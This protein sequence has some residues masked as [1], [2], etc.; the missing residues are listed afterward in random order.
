MLPVP[1]SVVAV[2]PCQGH[3]Q[4]HQPGRRQ[5]RERMMPFVCFVR[6]ELHQQ[7]LWLIASGTADNGADRT[8]HARI[9]DQGYVF[10]VQLRQ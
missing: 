7:L 3:Q 6:Y 1:R 4:G 10:R 5:Q 8:N 2:W 9:A